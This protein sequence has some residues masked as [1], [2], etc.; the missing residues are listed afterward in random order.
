MFMAA[1]VRPPKYLHIC[2]DP[3]WPNK[4]TTGAGWTDQNKTTFNQNQAQWVLTL[5][6]AAMHSEQTS[7]QTSSTTS[8]SDHCID[9][10]PPLEPPSRTPPWCHPCQTWL[11][12]PSLDPLSTNPPRWRSCWPVYAE[13]RSWASSGCSAHR[14]S[15]QAC[16]TAWILGNTPCPRRSRRRGLCQLRTTASLCAIVRARP[17][18]FRLYRP[19]PS[20]PGSSIDMTKLWLEFWKY[21]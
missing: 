3:Q 16:R 20:L 21:S 18:A 8:C 6:M 10:S 11:D 9:R 4:E 14:H 2:N 1:S 17:Q 12:V 7:E 13:L 15:I 5:T 19:L